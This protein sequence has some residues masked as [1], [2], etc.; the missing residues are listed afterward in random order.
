M[1]G[2]HGR[3]DIHEI[4]SPQVR[5]AMAEARVKLMKE[6]LEGTAPQA[7]SMAVKKLMLADM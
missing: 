3:D 4:N 1:D 2:D 5:P 7:K 6:A